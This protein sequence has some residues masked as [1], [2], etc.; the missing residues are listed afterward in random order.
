MVEDSLNGL[1]LTY[2]D[3]RKIAEMN[4]DL[5]F[6]THRF[7]LDKLTQIKQLSL[8][9]DCSSMEKLLQTKHSVQYRSFEDK[10]LED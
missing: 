10:I 9:Y 8:N 5:N 6:E 3:A 7:G 2:A 4:L 1:T